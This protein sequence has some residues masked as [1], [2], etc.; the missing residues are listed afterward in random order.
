LNTLNQ[1]ENI[2]LQVINLK[3]YFAVSKTAKVHAVDDVS[4][5][6]FDGE[7]LGLVGESGSG[8]TTIGR[9][10]LRLIEPE[11]G[12]VLYKGNDILKYTPKEM[13]SLRKVGQIIFQD[14]FSSLNPRMKIGDIIAEP[15]RIHSYGNK[16]A[17]HERVEYLVNRVGLSKDIIGSY[18]HELDGGRCQR[19]GVA[20]A[21]AM[22]P[23][24]VVCDEPVSALD[25]S[26]QAQVL[27]LLEDLCEEF[28]LT[29]LFI[30]HDLSV[31]RRISHRIVVL[32]LGKIMEMAT[33]NELFE[34]PL[35]PYT[36][37]L[38]SA[39]PT[40]N[41]D[42]RRERIILK[43]DVPTPINL[44]EGCR[45]SSRCEHCMERCTEETPKLLDRGT[46]HYVACHM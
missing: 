42:N 11:A 26:V 27:N 36:K 46:G 10:I 33:A 23:S 7:V 34:N 6:I 35:H 41:I 1:D 12:R 15:L 19:V 37:A 25:V 18:P 2:K 16:A 38:L 9:S 22:S 39:V 14:P 8:K 20:R 4:F 21:I 32:Y 40:L 30:S 13:K 31:V 43:G 28:N 17:I 29:Y 5:D 44:G 45:F 24:F 3:K